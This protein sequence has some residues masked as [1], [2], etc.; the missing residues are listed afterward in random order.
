M[1]NS[2]KKVTVLLL[3]SFFSLCT[4]AQKV[5]ILDH[6][7]KIRLTPLTNLNSNFRETNL[8]ITPDGKYLYFMS[9]RGQQS[10]SNQ[11]M[12]YKGQRVYD[13]DIWYTQKINGKWKSPSC[14]PYGINTNSGEDEPNISP[15][16][17]T[18]T[19]Q[20][21]KSF[22]ELDGGPY[23][24]AR[25]NGNSWGKPFGLGGGIT[26]FFVTTDNR[27]TDG[28]TM[29]PDGKTFIV[30]CG[31]DYDRKMDLYISKKKASG[32]T[33]LQKL[34]VSTSGDERSVFI[35]ADGKTIYFASDGYKGFGGLDIFKAE[36]TADGSLGEIIN[37]GAPFNTAEDDYGFI[38]TQDGKEAYFIRDG[39]IYFADLTQADDRIKPTVTVTLSGI[40]KDE[41]TG[42]GVPQAD[43]LIVD[44][45]TGK[46]AYKIKAKN[47]GKFSITLPNE[48]KR[49]TVIAASD[50]YPSDSKELETE[51]TDFE[52]SYQVNFTLKA[53]GEGPSAYTPPPPPEP[54]KPQKV[55]PKGP[56]NKIKPEIAPRIRVNSKV[57]SDLA[58]YDIAKSDENPYSFDG[59][60]TNHLILLLDAS[61]SM[62]SRD[63]LPL[64]K[65]TLKELLQ[66]MRPEDRISVIVYSGQVA[67][68]AECVS[69][70]KSED[71]EKV[72][73]RIN[74]GGGTHGKKG[75]KK[76]FDLAKTYYIEGGNNRIIMATDG[77][78]DVEKL[79]GLAGKMAHHNIFLSVFGFG[80]PKK[81]VEDKLEE[82]AIRGNGNYANINSENV[83]AALLKELKAF[84]A[85]K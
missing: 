38:L 50:G 72:M 40:V 85:F 29:S 12:T 52:H 6:K 8:S 14:L 76:A 36:I 53:D 82:L 69:S 62:A 17:K 20:S 84:K 64:L 45:K 81:E 48:E 65:N 23:Y 30:A 57:P 83:E 11:Y 68:A 1:K 61:G 7:D 16:G 4:F 9:V 58:S 56:F 46:T 60:A 18:V 77:A 39:D 49:Y 34:P 22:W 15:D 71:L 63:R 5:T 67:V 51:R 37:I 41:D 47:T 59:Y 27:A 44:T 28:M 78:F 73:N 24:S 80:K 75:L 70:S 3:L 13:G 2:Y 33:F 66:Y 26:D 43:I 42:K 21:W 10:W 19:F 32:W 74:A 35:A 79:N 25:M 55:Y 54:P 31:V